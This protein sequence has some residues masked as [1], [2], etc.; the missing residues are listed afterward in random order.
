MRFFF[1]ERK[2]RQM[3]STN[4]MLEYLNVQLHGL[5]GKPHPV[6]TGVTTTRDVCKLI[7]LLKFLTGDYLSFERLASDR[8][9]NDSHCRLCPSSCEDTRHILTDCRGTANVHN[10]LYLELVNSV[11]D[12]APNSKLLNLSTL[13]SSI[14]TQFLL[15]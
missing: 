2:W 3:A 15:D 1:A 7:I 8:N 13:T 6:L 12:L 9:T 4:S 11:A 14:L 5:S 10:R